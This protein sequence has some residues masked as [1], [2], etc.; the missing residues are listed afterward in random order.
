[1]CCHD[2]R[3]SCEAALEAHQSPREGSKI[4]A[5]FVT[6]ADESIGNI[7]VFLRRLKVTVPLPTHMT[8]DVILPVKALPRTLN[9]RKDFNAIDK[10]VLP[11]VIS[12]RVPTESFSPLE[13]RVKNIWKGVICADATADLKPESDFFCAGGN[14][15]L[16]MS[17]Q[18]ALQSELGCSLSLPDMFQFSTIRSM[19]ACIQGRAGDAQ[20]LIDG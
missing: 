14:S 20:G 19:A 1:M 12:E 9:G 6:F 2:H 5:A 18:N 16:L 10:L 17:L 13:M 15:L 7:D 11:E 8:P 4:L 3:A